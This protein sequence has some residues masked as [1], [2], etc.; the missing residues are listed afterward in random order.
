MLSQPATPSEDNI[1]PPS[2]NGV[3]ERLQQVI[4]EGGSPMSPI[5]PASPISPTS[6]MFK[7]GHGRQASLGTTMTSPSTRRRSLES[8]MSLIKE[9]V[10]GRSPSQDPELV[11]LANSMG[12]SGGKGT[13]GAAKAVR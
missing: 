1:P 10:D 9:V 13:N 12:E 7:R 4:A 2:P 3:A 8:T 11:K 6:S 5:S